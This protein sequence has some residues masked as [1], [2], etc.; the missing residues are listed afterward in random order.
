VRVGCARCSQAVEGGE[1]AARRT[2][3]RASCSAAAR[4]QKGRTQLAGGPLGPA[5]CDPPTAIRPPRQQ[6]PTDRQGSL[7]VRWIS[8]PRYF[9]FSTLSLQR[10]GAF[11]EVLL[12][13][14]FGKFWLRRK[15]AFCALFF[16]YPAWTCCFVY[17]LR[18]AE[19]SAKRSVL[20]LNL[21]PL[22]HYYLVYSNHSVPKNQEII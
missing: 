7:H 8:I 11:S 19:N 1:R 9:S 10:F 14:F 12:R 3:K 6:S 5:S 17:F 16:R 22:L 2:I 15:A 21:Y 4:H 18:V 20:K 13:L